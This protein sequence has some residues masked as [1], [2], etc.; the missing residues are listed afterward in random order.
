M[1]WELPFTMSFCTA[2]MQRFQT[3][4]ANFKT[5]SISQQQS[6]A[7]TVQFRDLSIAKSRNRTFVGENQL[8]KLAGSSTA[9]TRRSPVSAYG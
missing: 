6:S 5:G 1:G 8:L 7:V 9:L 3:V 2:S 4:A